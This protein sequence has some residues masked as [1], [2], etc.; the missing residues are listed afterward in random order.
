MW[1]SLGGMIAD[2]TVTVAETSVENASF[3][4]IELTQLP[5]PPPSIAEL[6]ERANVRFVFGPRDD[7]ST[8]SFERAKGNR[9]RRM[10]GLTEYSLRYQFRSYNRWRL[11]TDLDG[12]AARITIRYRDIAITREHTVWFRERPAND[13]FWS[14]RLVLH[15][16][17]HVRISCDP[18]LDSRFKEKVLEN[19]VI[20]YRIKQGESF[21]SDDA[22]RLVVEQVESLFAELGELVEIRYQELDRLTDHGINSL[23]PGSSLSELLLQESLRI[24]D[25]G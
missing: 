21:G 14:D 7:A 20:T 18:V 5:E 12:K 1:L 10:V 15:E 4:S 23:P 17:D 8:R 16:L 3:E 6:I 25:A 11:E 22:N 13:S 9:G 19:R 24:D 2:S